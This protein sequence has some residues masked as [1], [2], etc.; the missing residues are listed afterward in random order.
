MKTVAVDSR[1]SAVGSRQ[2]GSATSGQRT[3]AGGPRRAQRAQR[4]S[5]RGWVPAS[6]K[7]A[8]AAHAERERGFPGARFVRAGVL[9]ARR[10]RA[11]VGPRER[12]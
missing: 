3:G 11:G 10:E 12:L 9:S 4:E 5:E 6:A 8:P 7:K 1:E 2:L